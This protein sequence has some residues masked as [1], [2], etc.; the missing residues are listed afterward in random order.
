[1]SAD[2]RGE[3]ALGF[4]SRSAQSLCWFCLFL[5]IHRVL[6]KRRVSCLPPS[7]EGS[8]RRTGV[9][10]NHKGSHREKVIPFQPFSL[11]GESFCLVIESPSH[12]SNTCKSPLKKRE[13]GAPQ[14]QSFR[15][16]LAR[17]SQHHFV[18]VF[19]GYLLCTASDD[20]FPFQLEL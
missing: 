17:I 4:G 10:L 19:L 6:Y 18:F 3:G 14:A 12:I 13:E 8:L 9:A 1:M 16:H 20:V 2:A 11:R 7:G 15:P 5:P